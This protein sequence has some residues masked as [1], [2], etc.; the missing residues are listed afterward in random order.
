MLKVLFI[1]GFY[2]FLCKVTTFFVMF[3]LVLFGREH[4]A[5]LTI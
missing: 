3:L 5:E 2:L 1:G 4:N